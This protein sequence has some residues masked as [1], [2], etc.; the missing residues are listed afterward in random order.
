MLNLESQQIHLVADFPMGGD[1]ASRPRMEPL[2]VPA[3]PAAVIVTP[4]EPPR[5]ET[6]NPLAAG[7]MVVEQI[8]NSRRQ[9]R[10]LAVNSH[11]EPLRVNG[12]L[13][14][15]AAVL[16]E[17]DSLQLPDDT[18]LHV[19]FFNRPRNGKPPPELIGKQCP[20][21]RVPFTESAT[22]YIC[23]CGV[24]MHN[25]PDGE[26]D[27]LQCTRLQH[28]CIGCERPITLKEGFTYWPDLIHA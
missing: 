10:L 17:K 11:G 18:T 20:V 21:C 25:S 8:V 6:G 3:Q 28:A 7:A 13:A 26:A 24:A 22:V 9:L 2:P 27:G 14:P 12:Q 1:G 5:L 23:S 16:A 4:G 19:T 15:R